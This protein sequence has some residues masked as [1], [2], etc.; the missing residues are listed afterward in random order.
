MTPTSRSLKK[1]R[2]EGWIAEKVERP[3]NPY[4]KRTQ[5][6]FGFGDI[7]CFKGAI[8]MIVQTTSGDGGNVSARIQK[9]ES[10]AIA[11]KWADSAFRVIMVHGWAKRGAAGKRKLWTCREIRLANGLY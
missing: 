8:T 7:L 2:D 6:L 11:K 10:S 3:W 4:T 1:L 5:D 9:I